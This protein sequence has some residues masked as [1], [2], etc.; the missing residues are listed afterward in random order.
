MALPFSLRSIALVSCVLLFPAPVVRAQGVGVGVTGGINLSEINASGNELLNVVLTDKIQP[1]GGLFLTFATADSFWIQP[2]FLLSTK[3]SRVETGPSDQ[4]IRLRYIEVPVLFRYGAPARS[5]AQ[6]HLF[7]GPYIARLL[8]ADLDPTG[9]RQSSDISDGFASFDFGWVVGLGLGVGHGRF[10]L[11]YSGG[12]TDIGDS[13][14]L[15]GIVTV[16]AGSD[17]RFRNR[18]FVF[19]AAIRF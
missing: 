6:L 8:D 3:G 19:M 10:D 12:L 9:P 4:R 7:G 18:G 2:E 14:D 5:T 17:V 13:P 16:P 1:V 11:R 15:G